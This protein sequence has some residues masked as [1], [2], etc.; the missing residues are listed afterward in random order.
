[1]QYMWYK[2]DTSAKDLAVVLFCLP[3]LLWPDKTKAAPEALVLEL[4]VDPL[5][6]GRAKE[7]PKLVASEPAVADGETAAAAAPA[8]QGGGSEAAA[9]LEPAVSAIWKLRSRCCAA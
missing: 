3:H 5:R 7:E 6:P 9:A 2:W 1:M 8:S 4:A